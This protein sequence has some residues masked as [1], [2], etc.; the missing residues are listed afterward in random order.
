M[1]VGGYD[2]AFKLMFAAL[3]VAGLLAGVTLAFG[4][5]W[6][7]SVIRPWLHMVTA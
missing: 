5:P 4:V 6:L 3:L 1:G 7:W 2:G